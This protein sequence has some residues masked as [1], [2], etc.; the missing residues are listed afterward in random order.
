MQKYAR[1]EAVS[2]HYKHQ[3]IILASLQ[4]NINALGLSIPVNEIIN[5]LQVALLCLRH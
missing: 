4:Q 3:H 1:A 5:E 2:I